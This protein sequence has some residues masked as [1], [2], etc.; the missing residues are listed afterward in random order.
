MSPIYYYITTLCNVDY[1]LIYP[2]LK[3]ALYSLNLC[4][5]EKNHSAIYL[6]KTKALWSHR[7]VS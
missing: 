5:T 2:L 1:R 3:S 7:E 6:I 4:I